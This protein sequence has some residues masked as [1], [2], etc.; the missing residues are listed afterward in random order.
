MNMNYATKHKY[1]N[2]VYVD[3]NKNIYPIVVSI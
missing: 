1:S 2:F 3:T